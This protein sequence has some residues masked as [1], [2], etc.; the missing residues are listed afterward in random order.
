MQPYAVVFRV[1][2]IQLKKLQSFRSYS[3]EAPKGKSLTPIFLAVGAAGLAIGAYR[4][5]QTAGAEPKNREK[6]FTGGDQ[7][8]VTL[9][10]ADVET[11]SHNTKRLRF[12]FPDK[13]A[14]S[15]LPVTCE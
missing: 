13:E 8:W 5:S 9:K 15:G 1:P 4:Y 12:E 3:S 7:G 2:I 11:L 14:V 10:V 6:V